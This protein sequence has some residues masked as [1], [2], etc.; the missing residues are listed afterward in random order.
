MLEKIK[1][2]QRMWKNGFTHSE[3]KEVTGLS[4]GVEYAATLENITAEQ[5]FAVIPRIKEGMK[6][7]EIKSLFN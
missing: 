2:A 1:Q 6:F 5:V 7:S 4:G 3:I